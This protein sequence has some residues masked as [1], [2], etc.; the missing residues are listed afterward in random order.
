M[1]SGSFEDFLCMYL[2]QELQYR[3]CSVSDMLAFLVMVFSCERSCSPTSVTD[4]TFVAMPPQ[5]D[6]LRAPWSADGFFQRERNIVRWAL[7]MVLVKEITLVW[8][9]LS[10]VIHALRDRVLV[11]VLSFWE[12][13]G[14]SPRLRTRPWSLFAVAQ[15]VE[16]PY[17]CVVRFT[18]QIEFAPFQPDSSCIKFVQHVS[19]D[20]ML[21]VCIKLVQVTLWPVFSGLVVVLTLP[22]RGEPSSKG[23]RLLAPSLL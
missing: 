12:L 20:I 11:L 22:T 7:R 21:S 6:E 15:N 23:V 2:H 8:S 18:S 3:L 5:T 10:L 4:V 13:W 16:S 1:L 14:W 9:V 19:A 17:L